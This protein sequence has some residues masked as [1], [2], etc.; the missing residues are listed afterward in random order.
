MARQLDPSINKVLIKGAAHESTIQT[1]T[2]EKLPQPLH[3]TFHYKNEALAKR[4]THWSAHADVKLDER[5]GKPI[6]WYDTVLKPKYHSDG[7]TLV[8]DSDIYYD[9]KKGQE[10]SKWDP[11]R[12]EIKEFSEDVL[13]GWMI[14][15]NWIAW[16]PKEGKTVPPKAQEEVKQDQA[17]SKAATEA[18]ISQEAVEPPKS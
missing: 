6:N 2:G 13:K 10:W 15:A 14:S 7:K 18:L 12:N 17:E 11:N 3:Y 1:A 4:G 8:E 9:K 16:S 5:T